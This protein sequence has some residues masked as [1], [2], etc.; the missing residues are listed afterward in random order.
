M[1][2]S[3]FSIAAAGLARLSSQAM[4]SHPCDE[5][6]RAAGLLTSQV[7]NEPHCIELLHP[8]PWLNLRW[9]VDVESAVE[10][11]RVSCQLIDPKDGVARPLVHRLYSRGAMELHCPDLQQM[12]AVQGLWPKKPRDELA[13]EAA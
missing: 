6:W 5:T 3:S 7:V 10:E 1:G 4:V 13:K 8:Q 12:A 2:F 11:Q 9:P